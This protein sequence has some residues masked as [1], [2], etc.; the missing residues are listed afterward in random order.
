MFS[1]FTIA[2]AILVLQV[3]ITAS[4]ISAFIGGVIDKTGHNILCWFSTF[5]IG[6]ISGACMPSITAMIV[7][8]VAQLAADYAT[9]QYAVMRVAN[10]CLARRAA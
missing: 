1:V 5:A 2:M 6:L 9:R 8:I 4:L 10:G 7:L 3:V